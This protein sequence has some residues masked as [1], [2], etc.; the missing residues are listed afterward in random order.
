M[1]TQK[2]AVIENFQ[3]DRYMIEINTLRWASVTG[4]IA[5]LFPVRNFIYSTRF[6]PL[7]TLITSSASCFFLPGNMLGATLCLL[8]QKNCELGVQS[9]G[10]MEE[11]VVQTSALCP[12]CTQWSSQFLARIESKVWSLRVGRIALC[13]KPLLSGLIYKFPYIR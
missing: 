13:C 6:C 8:V 4:G 3:E 1:I 7:F 12:H 9:V 2:K 5:S 10:S 11:I